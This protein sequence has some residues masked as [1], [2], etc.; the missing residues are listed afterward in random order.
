MPDPTGTTLVPM[1]ALAKQVAALLVGSQM[2]GVDISAAQV[3]GTP[4]AQA[5]AQAA[6]LVVSQQKGSPLGIAGLDANG[7]I[8]TPLLVNVGGGITR[9]ASLRMSDYVNVKDFGA[10]GDAQPETLTQPEPAGANSIQVDQPSRVSVGSLVHGSNGQLYFPAGT[11]V[12]SVSGNVVSLS[13]ASNQAM[14]IG[15]A[16]DVGGTDDSAALSAAATQA[17]MSGQGMY[18]PPGRYYAPS[19]VYACQGMYVQL[20]HASMSSESTG[21]PSIPDQSQVI[22]SS[23]EVVSADLRGAGTQNASFVAAMF[24]PSGTTNSYQHNVQSITG[25]NNDPYLLYT[26]PDG[27]TGMAT[28]DAVGQFIA[29]SQPGSNTFGNTWVWNHVLGLEEGSNG[30]AVIGEAQIIN[31]RD[32]P[33]DDFD[34]NNTV[35]GYD[36]IYNCHSQCLYAHFFQ[37]APNGVPGLTNGLVFRRGAVSNMILGQLSAAYPDANGNNNASGHVTDL[38]LYS[39][40]LGFLQRLHVGGGSSVGDVMPSAGM[41]VA[42]DGSITAPSVTTAASTTTTQNVKSSLELGDPNSTQPPLIDFNMKNGASSSLVRVITNQPNTLTILQGT[43]VDMADLSPAGLFLNVPFS[44]NGNTASLGPMTLARYTH[45][46]LPSNNVPFGTFVVCSDCYPQGPLS[47]GYGAPGI[48]LMWNGMYWA[49]GAGYVYG[50]S[51][52]PAYATLHPMTR[53]QMRQLT[54]VSSGALVQ[55]TDDNSPAVYENGAWHLL[56]IGNALP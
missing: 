41:D 12:T 24:N 50:L 16:L 53:A 43:G 51:P 45:D 40:G 27:T 56:Q 8:N 35:G 33:G 1:S 29:M 30:S 19:A 14:P 55:D 39:N 42:S 47:N 32:T 49:D 3:N 54:G 44:T 9:T 25:R 7:N 46:K 15:A 18:F 13:A 26:K 11:T 36:E 34:G 22:A 17:C 48:M 28:H 37:G 10:K 5:I 6:T 2:A 4:V 38:A 20:S 23:G 52:A 31:S 21:L